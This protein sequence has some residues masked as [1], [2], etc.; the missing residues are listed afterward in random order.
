MEFTF[1]QLSM[2]LPDDCRDCKHCQTNC[3]QR[4]LRVDAYVHIRS[5]EVETA[6]MAG[7]AQPR[8]IGI[9]GPFY[10]LANYLGFGTEKG[11]SVFWYK[12]GGLSW[13]F[14]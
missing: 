3:R 9:W 1:A 2:Q 13:L 12:V 7:I 4:S 10:M 14:P 5:G 6:G 8:S 11:A